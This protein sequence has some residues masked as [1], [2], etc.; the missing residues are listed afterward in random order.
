MIALS[1]YMADFP[2]ENRAGDKL[3]FVGSYKTYSFIF[4]NY[5]YGIKELCAFRKH[6]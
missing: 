4:Q 6:I 3:K 2:T 1:N 5:Y